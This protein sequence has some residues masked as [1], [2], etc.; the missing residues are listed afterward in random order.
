VLTRQERALLARVFAGGPPPTR[1]SAAGGW[2]SRVRELARA[3][4]A[5]RFRA[6]E[7][8]AYAAGVADIGALYAR[9][10]GL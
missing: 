1:P 7:Q 5:R 6:A 3:Y 10:A 4:G 2:R 9:I 8:A